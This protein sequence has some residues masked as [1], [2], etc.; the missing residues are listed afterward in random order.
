MADQLTATGLH[1]DDLETRRAIKVARLRSAISPILDVSP[2]QPIGIVTDI[3]NEHDQQL[4]ELLQEIYSALDPDQA[5]GQSLDAVC[6]TTGTY[7]RG[8]TFGSVVL[9]VDL[10]AATTVPAGSQAAVAGDPDNQWAT[11]ED[12]T[13]IGAGVY[14]VPAQCLTAGPIQALAGTITVIVTPVVGWNSVTNALDA[15]EGRDIESNI[16]LRLRRKTEVTIGG[17]SSVDSLAAEVSQVDGV[18]EVLCLENDLSVTANG[19]PRHSFEVVYWDGG[20]GAASQTEIAHEI[21]ETKA[22]TTRAFGT[23]TISHTDEQG[24][25]HAIGMTLATELAIDVEIDVDVDAADYVGD[26][27]V[28][29]AVAAWGDNALGIGDAVYRSEISA[30]A[31][32]LAGVLNV[33]AVRLAIIPAPP[34]AADVFVT[35]RQIATI[36]VG[37]VTVF[38]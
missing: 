9:S 29:A 15:V 7:R 10:D 31:V 26:A 12:V 30:V 34:A 4:V 21:F 24:N 17:S 38:S 20:A 18:L 33:S 3:T 23:T 14:T 36:A 1:I 35:N 19:I 22:A 32:V 28:A 25:A 5:T 16:A 8:A 37:D 27:A 2:D 13:S 11:T 6:S